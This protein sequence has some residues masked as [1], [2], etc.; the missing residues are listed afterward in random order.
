[1]LL[2][3]D[4]SPNI[5]TTKAERKQKA[6]KAKCAAVEE[7][8]YNVSIIRTN[9]KASLNKAILLSVEVPLKKFTATL[10]SQQEIR[11]QDGQSLKNITAM[12]ASQQEIRKQDGQSLKNITAMQASQQE[13]RKQ[14][15]QSL[16]TIT[17][18]HYENMPI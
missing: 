14:E 5:K 18:M 9:Q 13:I 1:M 2:S 16:K 6:K 10:A 12:Q 3:L 11:K 7:D 8:D 17:A 4:A 15:G